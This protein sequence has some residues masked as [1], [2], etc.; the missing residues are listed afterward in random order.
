MDTAAATPRLIAFFLPQFHPI[1]E[2]D[3]WWGPGFTEWTNVVQARRLFPGHYQPHLP[4]DLGFYDL[5]LPDTREAQAE[6]ASAYSI[7]AF[8]YYHYWFAGRRL[9]GRPLDEVL[10]LGVPNFPFCICWA[11]EDWTR[12][13][14]GRSREY[15]VQQQYSA[16]DDVSHI[17]ALLPALGDDRY[18]RVRGKPLLIVYRAE[19]LPQPERTADVWRSE[20]QRAGLGDLQLCCV[21]SHVSR[22]RLPPPSGF[23]AV[24]EF[25]PDW[26]NLPARLGG[27]WGNRVLARSLRDPRRGETLNVYRYSDLAEVAQRLAAPDYLY[28][29]CVAPGWDNT[30]RRGRKAVL[31]H[32]STPVLYER[33]LAAEMS[34]QAGRATDEGLVFINAW[35][36]WAEGAHL[37]PCLRWGRSY[38]EATARAVAWV[39]RDARL[40]IPIHAPSLSPAQV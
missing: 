28:Y 7:D 9:L 30:P 37:E 5:R 4:R 19:S 34:R 21:N 14:D 40:S 29:P 3:R 10:S 20:A 24:I 16:E 6:L 1:P 36:E 27:L 26:G 38:L 2:N 31:F 15:L 17:R 25:Q 11:N 22:G 39:A 35:N 18:V 32:G 8:C 12:A 13:W 33:W 23:D